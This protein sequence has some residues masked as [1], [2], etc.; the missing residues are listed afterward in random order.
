M[1]IYRNVSTL[2]VLLYV[3]SNII[4]VL[5]RSSSL[6]DTKD[7]LLALKNEQDRGNIGNKEAKLPGNCYGSSDIDLLLS[8]LYQVPVLIFQYCSNG[9]GV[10]LIAWYGLE[11]YDKCKFCCSELILLMSY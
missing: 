1:A 8:I 2:S 11:H 7:R 9:G 4:A 10:T 3:L 6:Q 5:G